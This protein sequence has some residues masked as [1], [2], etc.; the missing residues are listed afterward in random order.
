MLASQA[1]ICYQVSSVVF[2][3]LL[4]LTELVVEENS[5]SG[6]EELLESS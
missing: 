5:F 4:N 2:F 1:A 3:H 6:S